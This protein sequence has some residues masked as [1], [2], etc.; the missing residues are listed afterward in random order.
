MK[1]RKKECIFKFL[2]KAE[3]D[4]RGFC[5]SRRL[6]D[7]YRDSGRTCQPTAGKRRIKTS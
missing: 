6:G 3:D 2:F 4:I 1:K 5:L 7:V